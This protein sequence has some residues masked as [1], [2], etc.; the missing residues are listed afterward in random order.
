MW[1]ITVH[2]A[3]QEELS[4]LRA[5]YATPPPPGTVLVHNEREEWKALLPTIHGIDAAPDG[6][7]IRLMIATGAILP[8]HYL[9]EGGNANR[10]TAAEMGLPSMKRFQ[11]RQ[12]LFR[13]LLTRILD[14]VL[15]E[16][17]KAGRLG[18]RADRSFTIH[19]EEISDLTP[20]SSAET[21]KALSDALAVAIANQLLTKEEARQMWLRF[22]N[23]VDDSA[24]PSEDPPP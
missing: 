3:S 13:A 18:H 10:A 21:L 9:A 7:A 4:R 11:R 2:G 24:P 22:A 17:V 8:E 16:A 12:Q 6:R 15:D 19:F 23:L 20:T 1:D 5:A 14:R